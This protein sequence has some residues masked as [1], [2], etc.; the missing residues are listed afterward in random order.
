MRRSSAGGSSTRARVTVRLYSAGVTEQEAQRAARI[1]AA[2]RI[3]VGYDF[4]G[5][6][7]DHVTLEVFGGDPDEVLRVPF[8][9]VRSVAQAMVA[10]VDEQPPQP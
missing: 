4:T 6:L 3:V 2:H 1:A 8:D 10:I 9:Q 5:A 7:G